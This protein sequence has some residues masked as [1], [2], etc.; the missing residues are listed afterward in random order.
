MSRYLHVDKEFG[1]WSVDVN[2]A[3]HKRISPL[4]ASL[5]VHK[6]PVDEA[7]CD[8]SRSHFAGNERAFWMEGKAFIHD[9]NISLT[10]EVAACELL[11]VEVSVRDDTFHWRFKVISNSPSFIARS[12]CKLLEAINFHIPFSTGFEIDWNLKHRFNGC[13]QNRSALHHDDLLPLRKAAA[14]SEVGTVDLR[15]PVV[16]VTTLVQS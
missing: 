14:L 10:R 12:H 15:S 5:I 3:H 6:R 2:A 4:C 9:A 1:N 11:D 13:L 16:I 7:N 8:H